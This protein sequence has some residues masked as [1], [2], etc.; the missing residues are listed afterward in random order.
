MQPFAIA[1]HYT[2]IPSN[3]TA[4]L[5]A[6]GESII[7]H[8]IVVSGTTAATVSVYESDGITLIMDLKVATSTSFESRTSFIAHRGIA[9]TTPANA[10]C[11]VLHTNGSA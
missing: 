6:G 4:L 9:I 11:V 3:S 7:V 8:G 1:P 5:I 10:T 2:S